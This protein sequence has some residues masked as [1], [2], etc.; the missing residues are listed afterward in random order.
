MKLHELKPAPGSRAKSRRVGRG[1]GSG[2]V[3]TAGRG[4][5]GHKARSGGQTPPGFEGGQMPLQRRVPKRGFTNIFRK[6]IA[7]VNLRDLAGFES[8]A[9]VDGAALVKAGLVKGE[10][11]G[12]KLL[13][14]GEIGR[15]LHVKLALVSRAA[16]EKIEAAG[17][18]IEGAA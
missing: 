15:P 14:N 13:G 3:K 17:G 5:K 8:G 16:R 1:V 18:K 11:D 10:W 9:V 12:I 6:R 7:V 2:W 4:S